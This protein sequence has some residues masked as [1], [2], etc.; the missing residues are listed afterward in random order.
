MSHQ[1]I[2]AG[3]PAPSF[4]LPDQDGN[5]VSLKDLAGSWTVVYFYPKDDTPGCTREACEFSSILAEFAQLDARVIGVS[6]DSPSSHRKFI[7]K[8]TLNLT[9]L[10]DPEH[11]VL[12]QYGAWGEK[13]M[14]G[15]TYEGVLRSTVVIDPQG[16]IACHWPNVKPAG[17]AAAVRTRLAELTS[18]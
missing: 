5:P 15:R 16:R 12:E 2:E 7:D 6:P 13:S 10:S 18:A 14:Y 9:L 8:H 17:H 1:P 11:S 4:T 3:S